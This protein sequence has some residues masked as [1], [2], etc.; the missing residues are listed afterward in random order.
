MAFI[1]STVLMEGQRQLQSS[2]RSADLG[3]LML[4]KEV[5]MHGRSID[6]A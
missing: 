1:L 6:G 5:E 3:V 4:S 2:S